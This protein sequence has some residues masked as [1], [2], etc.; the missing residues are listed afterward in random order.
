MPALQLFIYILMK[1]APSIDPK[2]NFNRFDKPYQKLRII[3][4]SFTTVLAIV[5][6]Y[7]A[8]GNEFD[9]RPGLTISLFLLLIMIG[10]YLQSVKPNYI[11]GV[12]TPWTLE[13][14]VVWAKTNRLMG[15]TWFYGGIISLVVYSFIPEDWGII[16]L[17]GFTTISSAFSLVYS[18][19]V[20]RK[21][22]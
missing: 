17:V 20:F 16:L 10:N 13:S 11:F 19:L 3:F 1:Y 8:Q 15:K 12:R 4:Q 18:Y 2:K 6:L 9:I 22:R 5:I 14:E 21:L 7:A